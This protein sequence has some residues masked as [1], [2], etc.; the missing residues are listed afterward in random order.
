MHKTVSKTIPL[1]CRDIIN[2]LE[3]EAVISDAIL[4]LASRTAIKGIIAGHI[5]GLLSEDNIFVTYNCTRPDN[6]IKTVSSGYEKHH[7]SQPIFYLEVILFG[8]T[9]EEIVK[10][11]N[12]C[13]TELFKKFGCQ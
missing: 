12:E 7:F 8:I 2:N 10:H 1:N 5:K 11:L 4:C 9:E 3:I 6:L 13:F